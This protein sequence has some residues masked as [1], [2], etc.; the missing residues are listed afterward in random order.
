MKKECNQIPIVTISEVFNFIFSCDQQCLEQIDHKF[1]RLPYLLRIFF[2]LTGIMKLKHIFINTTFWRSVCVY[3]CVCV[4]SLCMC[5]YMCLCECVYVYLFMYV[6]F[7][8][9][10]EN[11]IQQDNLI[12]KN[13]FKDFRKEI[14]HLIQ[15]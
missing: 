12:Y 7:V 10:W 4:W 3:V 8:L 1:K 15:L 11:F 2:F 5:V 13:L 6:S 9:A 14:F